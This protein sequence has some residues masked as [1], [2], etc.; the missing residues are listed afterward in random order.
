MRRRRDHQLRR[1]GH[2]S[3]A[4]RLT[5]LIA[6]TQLLPPGVMAQVE[7]CPS[8]PVLSGYASIAALNNDISAEVDRIAGGG[9]P[10]EEYLFTLCPRHVFEVTEPLLPRLSGATFQC[11]V[12]GASTDNCVL[13]G[14]SEQIRVEDSTIA[15]YPI[16][17]VLFRGLTFESFTNNEQE[18]GTSVNVNASETTTVRF[19]DVAWTVCTISREKV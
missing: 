7:P 18:T 3:W 16:V 12:S 9:T 1:D 8:N 2:A 11:G 10:E 5:T 17:N 4:L 19:V 6:A 13:R 14:G 15:T